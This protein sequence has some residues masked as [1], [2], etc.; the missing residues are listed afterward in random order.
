VWDLRAIRKQL[1][2]MGLDWNL[3]TLP[4]TAVS[5]SALSVK[6]DL[7]GL[8][9]P[10]ARAEPSADE[11]VAVY[12]ARLKANPD[13][14]QAF[15]LRGHAYEKLGKYAEAVADFTEAQ[16]RQPGNPH[17]W[18]VRG[19]NYLRLEQHEQAAA[20]FRKS[21]SLKAEQPHVCNKLAWL[22][23]TGP[24][25][26]RNV[27]EALPLAERAVKLA[28]EHEGGKNTLGVALYRAERYEAAI[29]MLEQ[30]LAAGKGKL[31]AYDLFFLAMCHA[32]RGGS[33]RAKNYYD[34]AIKWIESQKNMP[35]HREALLK[36]IRAEA[37]EVRA[38]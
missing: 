2:E 37:E 13:D 3:P 38:K 31:D 32:K 20:D 6:V 5:D 35:A 16:M 18:E 10:R 28:P 33:D 30:S 29:A 23:L 36:A 7:G 21:L 1:A 24:E 19:D 27:S 15:H 26:L 17:F 22:L 9:G 11:Q 8:A 25:S 14:I 12:T 34:R 4:A